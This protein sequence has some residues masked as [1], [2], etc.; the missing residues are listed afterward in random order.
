MGAGKSE[1]GRRLADRLGWPFYDSDALVAESAG[2]AVAE[3]FQTEG[4]PSFRDREAEALQRLAAISP[5]LVGA[6]G[7]GVVESPENRD[8]LARDFVVVWLRLEPEEAARRVG[9]DPRRPLLA[10]GDAAETLQR[11]SRH[12]EAW[13]EEVSRI[14][15]DSAREDPQALCERILGELGS[16]DDPPTL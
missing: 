15:L 3:I 12:R 7:G 1:V 13:Y 5:P 9:N 16:V 10:G 11:L 6:L 2:I 14:V 8:R 4:E